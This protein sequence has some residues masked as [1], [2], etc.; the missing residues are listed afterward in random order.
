MKSCLF[1]C[2]GNK[3]TLIR[4]SRA[5]KNSSF[6]LNINASGVLLS[7]GV[8]K[9]IKEWPNLKKIEKTI[10]LGK[11]NKREN[12]CKRILY[13]KIETLWYNLSLKIDLFEAKK[14]FTV[15]C[16]KWNARPCMP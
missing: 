8:N 6:E 11:V 12:S 10:I 13:V 7:D 9:D 5:V 1:Y 4:F 2:F 14:G 3:R 15:W 16:R